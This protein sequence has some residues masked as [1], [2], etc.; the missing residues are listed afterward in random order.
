MHW[1]ESWAFLCA[2]KRNLRIFTA[3]QPSVSPWCW[4]VCKIQQEL[5]G[6]K[7]KTLHI[8]LVDTKPSFILLK[9][10]SLLA[11]TLQRQSTS[12]YYCCVFLGSFVPSLLLTLQNHYKNSLL[13]SR[14]HPLSALHGVE[15]C[16]RR[17]GS[18]RLAIAAPSKSCSAAWMKKKSRIATD[19]L[20]TLLT[21]GLG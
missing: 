13:V 4:C 1:C 16:T 15:E 6:L 8:L 5:E 21:Y 7:V 20:G 2:R 10:L 12:C 19:F 18:G 14:Q 9:K 17:K 11:T 3:W